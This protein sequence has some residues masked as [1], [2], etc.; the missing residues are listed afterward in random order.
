MLVAGTQANR[1]SVSVVLDTVTA[2]GTALCRESATRLLQG[3]HFAVI[4]GNASEIRSM[5]GE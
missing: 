1:I 5:A 2:G 4:R 3:V